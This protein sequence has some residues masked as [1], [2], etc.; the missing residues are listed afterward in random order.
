MTG[1]L[2]GKPSNSH[3]PSFR[4]AGQKREADGENQ[5]DLTFPIES[6]RSTSYLSLMHRSR[7]YLGKLC[8]QL[9]RRDARSLKREAL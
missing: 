6:T 2:D 1:R 3:L 8:L 5:K 7:V 4:G 9:E